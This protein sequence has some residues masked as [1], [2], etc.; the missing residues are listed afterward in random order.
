MLP[1]KS[2]RIFSTTVSREIV[3]RLC[4]VRLLAEHAR[5]PSCTSPLTVKRG[6]THCRA[7]AWGSC[8]LCLPSLGLCIGER[9]DRICVGQFFANQISGREGRG[10]ERLDK[11]GKGLGTR[12]AREGRREGGKEGLRFAEHGVWLDFLSFLLSTLSSLS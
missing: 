9:D 12:E 3:A 6:L 4:W 8:E 2:E 7:R 1:K 11:D 5:S 10:Q